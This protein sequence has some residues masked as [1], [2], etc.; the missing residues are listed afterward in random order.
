MKIT[1]FFIPALLVFLFLPGKV[2]AQSVVELRKL[3]NEEWLAMSTDERLHSLQVSNNRA[4]NQT[5][6]GNFPRYTE[7]YSRWGYDYYEMEE[8]YEN[9]AFRG[10]ENFNVIEDRRN[11]W[12]YNQFGD[13]LTKMTRNALIWRET[14]NDDGSYDAWLPGNY[15]NAQL[16]QNRGTHDDYM[17]KDI[18]GVW[19][20]R[21]STEDWA[22]S[23]VG[24]GSL[25]AKL[26]PLT[27]NY[28]N[29]PGTKA[30]FQSANYQVSIVNS[31]IAGKNSPGEGVSEAKYNNL[32]L[33]GGQFRRKFGALTLG[34][35]YAATYSVQTNREEGSSWK[36]TV[37]DYTPTP[38][39]YAV[40]IVDDS[41]QDGGGP[42]IHD[43]KIKV[44]GVYRPDILP[45]I[46]L[47]D[48]RNDLRTAV[49]NINEKKYVTVPEYA[50]QISERWGG[51]AAPFTQTTLYERVPKYVDYLYMNDFMHG[52]NTKVMAERFNYELGKEYYKYID[53][54]GKPFQVNGNE[55]VVYLFDLSCITDKVKR[56]QAEIT[57]ANDYKIQVAEIFTPKTA[58]GHAKLGENY[59]WYKSSFW[60][61]MAQS[62]GNIK[63]SSNL[64]TVT[65]D[66]AWEVGNTIYGFDGHFNYHGFKID[67]EYVTN[68][69]Y[70]MFADGAPGTGYPI[71]RPEDLTPREGGRST[72]RDNAYYLIAQKDWQRFGFIGEYFKMGKFY[73][74][75]MMY[76]SPTLGR[77]YT[78]LYNSYN[79]FLRISTIADNDD[80]DQYPDV[81]PYAQIMSSASRY[82]TVMDPDGVFPGND[83]DHDA[84]PDNEK[85]DNNF[86]DYNE[87]FLMFDV[88]PDDFVFGDDYNNNNVPDFRED[89]M[90]YDTPYDLDRQG[91]HVNLRFTPQRNVNIYL[92]SFRTRGIGADTRTDDDYLKFILNYD[93]YSVGNIYAE[94]RYHEIQDN[95]QD[96]FVI[97][98]TL[99]RPWS[100]GGTG[101]RY[102]RYFYYDE[103]EY[104]NSKVNKLFLESRIRA[105]PS[106]TLENHI[107][108]IRNKQVEGTMYDNI[109]QSEDILT[110]FAMVNKFVYTKQ[111]GNWIFSPGVKFRLY[112]KS[113]SE[114]INPLDHYMMRIPLV[115]LKYS[116]SPRTAI[117]LG[118]QGFKGFELLYRDYIQSHNDYR[119]KNYTLE[120]SNRTTYFGFDVWGGFGVK[121]EQVKFEEEYRG[122]EEYKSSTFFVQMWLGY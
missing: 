65:V 120:V 14:Y 41:P 26:T 101:S 21:E 108:F 113:R 63:D 109:F 121:M 27:L 5:F 54:G 97:V 117:T 87:P 17:V 96:S 16:F 118:L 43:V 35:N 46:I 1:T 31:I 99:V 25:R 23:I 34:A 32:M 62:N 98:P 49:T 79:D 57:V 30:D 60:K 82:R 39:L 84:L 103:C 47:D 116:I 52:W 2:S 112:K 22:V 48:L 12:Y 104:R 73:R 40:R 89:D 42:I 59:D 114:S 115:H 67:G 90:K 106:I 100:E 51:N 29:L 53:P 37:R 94:Y 122:F 93:V 69:H 20:A 78:F 24:S 71:T 111:W 33:R 9:Y 95:F 119:Q 19:V 85:N 72:V 4:R 28:P 61:T 56:V 110:T 58:G 11:K 88:D 66:F 77:E 18:D 91:H 86:P 15:I 44:D 68:T 8:R 74:P 6:V 102:D 7:L 64:R 83:L 45:Q 13:R 80:D 38:M 107:K 105:I 36:G 76:Y 50:S 10:F 70:Y 3:T 81:M 75:S 92:G 55:Y